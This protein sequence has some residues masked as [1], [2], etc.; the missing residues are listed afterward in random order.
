MPFDISWEPEGVV[1]RHWGN[2][3]VAER[4]QS[5]EAICNDPRFDELHY[6]ISDYLGAQHYEFVPEAT[7]E[8]VALHIAPIRTNPNIVIAGVATH[9]NALAGIRH[10]IA[11][12]VITQP[13]EAFE[14][15][16]AA[17]AW[18]ASQP[19]TH[20]PRRRAGSD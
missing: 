13:Y 10:F 9:P 8:T 12:G 5:L 20:A 15:V 2:V 19:R 16:E 4:R 3:T 18:I 11:Q 1:R 7:E 14:T 17:R 6:V